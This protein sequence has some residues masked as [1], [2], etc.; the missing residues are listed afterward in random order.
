MVAIAVWS[1]KRDDPMHFWA[2]NTV[3]PDEIED[4][5]AYNR[6]NGLMWSAYAVCLFVAGVLSLFNT[7]AG[8][9]SL[10][11]ICVPGVIIMMLVYRRIYGKYARK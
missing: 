11:L 8:V 2:G 10:S 3:K 5:P 6:A 7:L 1:F 4:I 9:I